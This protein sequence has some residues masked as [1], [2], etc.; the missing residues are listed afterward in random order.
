[1]DEG[2]DEDL[3]VHLKSKVRIRGAYRTVELRRG[4]ITMRTDVKL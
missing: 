3:V 2:L 1:M 4:E